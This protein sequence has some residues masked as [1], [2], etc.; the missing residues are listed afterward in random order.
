MKR[1]HI[2]TVSLLFMLVGIFVSRELRTPYR[3]FVV[4]NDYIGEI[5]MRVDR[6][7]GRWTISRGLLKKKWVFQFT[8]DGTLNVMSAM[9]AHVMANEEWFY[10]DGRLLRAT[11]REPR[12]GR[13]QQRS[14]GI[15]PTKHGAS[16]LWEILP[17]GN[18]AK[19]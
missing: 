6:E 9:R 5:R 1:K 7:N 14:G 8:D 17:E 2:V 4:P 12:K 15:M 11:T 16:M 19:M 13:V 3:K 10:E 18:V